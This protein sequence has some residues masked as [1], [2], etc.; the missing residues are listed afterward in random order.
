MFKLF[1]IQHSKISVN[2]AD[3]K[4]FSTLSTK[5]LQGYQRD[6]YLHENIQQSLLKYMEINDI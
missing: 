4:M 6:R 1:N 3:I 5:V 2:E